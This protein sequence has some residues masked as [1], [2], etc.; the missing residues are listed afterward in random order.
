MILASVLTALS[1]LVTL[2]DAAV[3]HPILSGRPTIPRLSIPDRVLTSPN[4]TV[5]PSIKTVYNFDQL[6]DHDHPNLGT[7]RQRY[8]MSWEFY[9]PGGPIILMT[10]GEENADGFDSY[11]TNATITGMIAQQQHGAAIV[12]EHRF[13][14]ESNPYN[15]LSVKSLEYLTIQQAIDD[16]VYFAQTATLPM[17]GG[18]N[19]KPK[20][21]PWILVG[22][23]YAG[24]LTSWT[25]VNKP[26]VFYAGYSSSGVVEAI[27]DFYDYFTPVREYMPKNCSSDVQAVIAYLDQIYDKGDTVAQRLL[28]EAFGLGGLSHM[29]DFA[30]ALRRNLFD[31]QKL[32]PASGPGAM[33][34]KF[35]DALEVKNGVSAPATGWG[36]EYAVHAWA[37]FWKNTYYAHLCGNT[38]AEDCL[39]TYD[40]TK[41]SWTNPTVNN[42]GRSWTWMVCNQVGYFQASPPKGQPAIISQ[43][44]QPIYD[45]R[46]CVNMFPEKFSTP[47]T[48][49]VGDVNLL[50]HGWNVGVDKLFFANGLR[51]PWREATVSAAGS[52]VSSTSAQPIYEGGGFHCSD[53]LRVSG[54]LDKTVYAVQL[55]G[56]ESMK[57]WLAK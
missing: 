8:W 7:F 40:T 52:G 48:P 44:L 53:M 27:S 30:A 51:D 9:E 24:A 29:D 6:I 43:I 56:L 46:R 42:A 50:Y 54:A 34:Y 25:M 4:G 39:G 28:K 41:S 26:G 45:A 15:D 13:F 19:V 3:P 55:A 17:P 2:A 18:G 21:T 1:L 35:C 22:G 14:G 23:S 12:L 32:Q 33:F 31:W 10:P 47:P 49:A 38:A 5:L 20:T 11:L 16:L 57:M 36:L 37:S